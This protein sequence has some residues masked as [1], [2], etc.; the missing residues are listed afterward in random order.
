GEKNDIGFRQ[1]QPIGRLRIHLRD[2]MTKGSQG[3]RDRGAGSQRDLALGAGTSQH[4][5]DIERLNLVHWPKISTSVSSSMPR[6][7]RAVCFIKSISSRT[8]VAVALPSLTM[9]FPCTVETMAP[10]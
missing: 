2:T 5:D 8:S 6:L 7:L 1:K 3:L 10:P 9:K 4:D